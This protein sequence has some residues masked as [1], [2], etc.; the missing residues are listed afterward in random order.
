MSETLGPAAV[1]LTGERIRPIKDQV[2]VKALDWSPSKIIH[3][4]GNQRKTLRGVV[5]AVGP[6]IFPTQYNGPKGYRTRSWDGT[7]FRPTEVKVGEIVELG[8]LELDG[9]KHLREVWQDDC[10]HVIAREEDIVAVHQ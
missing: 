7:V 5:V 1:V 3:V 4:A 6:G 2:V 8:G 10:L 9:Y